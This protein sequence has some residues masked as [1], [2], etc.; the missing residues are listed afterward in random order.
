MNEATIIRKRCWGMGL[1][2]DVVRF[3]LHWLD[4]SGTHTK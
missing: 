2:D 4:A 1:W 3:V